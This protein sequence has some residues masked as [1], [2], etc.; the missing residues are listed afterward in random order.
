MEYSRFFTAPGRDPFDEVVWDTRDALIANDRGEAVFEQR[1]RA[2]ATKHYT[3]LLK[4]CEH[5]DDPGRTELVEARRF[6]VAAAI[7]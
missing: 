1:D 5:A 3:R 6:T 2:T 4:V 7:R